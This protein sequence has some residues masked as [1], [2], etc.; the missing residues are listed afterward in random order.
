MNKERTAILIFANTAQFEA[1]QKAFPSSKMLFD[2]LNTQILKIVNET[3]LP[4]YHFSEKEQIGTT[5][6]E[7]F[8]NAIA[9]VFKMGYGQVI[10]VG[11]DTPH[12]KAYHI[13][14]G[15]A[16]TAQVGHIRA[17][18]TPRCK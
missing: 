2:K 11:N 7:R 1:E 14:V 6:A 3:G 4:Y 13:L 5:F 12:L 18:A 15:E 8:S 9:A 17:A 10:T 16:V